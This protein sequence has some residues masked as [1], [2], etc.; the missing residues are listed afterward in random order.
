[1][2]EAV[3]AVDELVRVAR[4]MVARELTWGDAGN[5]SCRSTDE[6]LVTASGARLGDLTADDVLRVP[7]GRP[8]GDATVGA[9]RTRDA[10]RARRPSKEL[11]LHRACYAARPDMAAVL[12]GAP[13][14]ATLVACCDLAVPDGLFVETMHYLERVARVPYHHPG[15]EELAAAVGAAARSAEVL[16]LENHG[17]VVLGEN[18]AEA[19]QGLQVLELACRMVVTARS[20]GIA[21]RP[22]PDRTVAGF[23]GGAGYKRPRRRPG[24]SG[25]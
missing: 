22:L 7:L 5:V 3:P 9:T 12:H 18:P 1:M 6:L 20:A 15:S 21:L 23:R 10:A 4:E 24:E 17:V 11:P 8:A 25:K 13:F 19:L 2:T 16:L 14:H